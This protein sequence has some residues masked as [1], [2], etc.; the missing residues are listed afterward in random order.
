[1]KK[2]DE[3]GYRV[4]NSNLWPNLYL[5][6]GLMQHPAKHKLWHANVTPIQ[7]EQFIFRGNLPQTYSPIP[8]TKYTGVK[9]N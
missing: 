3:F 2:K 8:V 6:R 7:L 4:N 1:M 5:S 9:D